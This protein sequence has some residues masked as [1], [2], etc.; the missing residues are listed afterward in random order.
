MPPAGSQA[1]WLL[2]GDRSVQ[3]RVSDQDGLRHPTH[4]GDSQGAEQ[5]PGPCTLLVVELRLKGPRPAEPRRER[6]CSARRR[7]RD[8][9]E[10]G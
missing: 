8:G 2:V 3:L 5:Q 6:G 9:W 1:A 10:Q 7:A 4:D